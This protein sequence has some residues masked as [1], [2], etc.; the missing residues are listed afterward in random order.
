[1]KRLI[2]CLCAALALTQAARAQALQDAFS[3]IAARD[4]ARLGQIVNTGIDAQVTALVYMAGLMQDEGLCVEANPERA[5]TYL[6][7]AARQGDRQAALD[8]GL[9]YALGDGLARSYA[10]A[11]AW[12]A[13]ATALELRDLDR[14]ATEERQLSVDQQARREALSKQPNAARY[15]T[16]LPKMPV[17]EDMV[18]EWQGYLYAVHYLAA[19]QIIY[20]REA[21]QIGANGSYGIRVCP[22][23]EAVSLERIRLDSDRGP[24]NEQTAADRGLRRAVAQAYEDA[25]RSLPRPVA[26]P[27]QGSCMRSTTAFVLKQRR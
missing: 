12:L 17:A 18:A 3:A 26:A 10:R 22:E 7:A 15:A 2:V 5:R 23:S 19:R 4:C 25:M 24:S 27:S 1:M 11:S 13:H 21:L 6:D 8:I 16:S 14:A 9:R 20:P